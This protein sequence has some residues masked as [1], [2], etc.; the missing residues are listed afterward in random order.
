MEFLQGVIQYVNTLTPEIAIVVLMLLGFGVG[1]HKLYWAHAAEIGV[2]VAI[3][4]TASNIAPQW[5]HG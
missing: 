2:A 5:L 1:S 4:L 3:A